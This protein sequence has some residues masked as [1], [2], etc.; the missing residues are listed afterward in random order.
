M[1]LFHVHGLMAGLLA[2]LLAQASVVMPVGG[3]FSAAAFWVDMTATS[4]TFYTA[5]P[6][7]HQVRRR[8]PPRC[9]PLGAAAGTLATQLPAPGGQQHPHAAP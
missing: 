2:P 8:G 4:C 9:T 5:V 7:M 6:T 1:P 3:K